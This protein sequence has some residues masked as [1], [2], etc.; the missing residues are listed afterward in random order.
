MKQKNILFIVAL[1]STIPFIVDS[2]YVFHIAVMITLMSPMAMSMNLLLK[3]GRL[4]LAQPAFMGIGAYTCALMAMKLG[5]PPLVTLT[6]GGIAAAIVAV[7]LGP[8]FLRIQGVYFVLLTYAF[9]QIVNLGIQEWT[10]MTGGNSGL[11]GVPKFSLL[12]FRFVDISYYYAIGL[13][14]TFLTYVLLHRIEK[15]DIGAIFQS[16]TA[17]EPLSNSLGVSSLN[18]RITAFGISAFISGLS[19]GIYAFYMGFL[20]PEP[21][22]FLA[23]VDLIVINAIG[24]SGLV[25][26]ALLGSIVVIPLPELLRDARQF[27][28]LIYGV[29]LVLFLVFLRQGLVSKVS[30]N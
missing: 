11:Y 2:R 3:V 8:I 23:S 27:Q 9:A 7:L 16:I 24:G 1:L 18:W 21:F 13:V 28:L 14:F 15:S 29:C 26:G 4:S 6:L 5:Y 22:G 19:G 10:S 20:S 12:D 17:D 25:V 30:Q